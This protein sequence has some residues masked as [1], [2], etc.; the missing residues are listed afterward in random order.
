MIRY[1]LKNKAFTLIDLILSLLIISI[2]I[3]IAVERVRPDHIY[4]LKLTASSIAQD[5]YLARQL[6]V[7]RSKKYKVL[8]VRYDN[9]HPDSIYGENNANN[10]YYIYGSSEIFTTN[11]GEKFIRNLNRKNR[12]EKARLWTQIITTEIEFNSLGYLV[13]G[14]SSEVY[15]TNGEDTVE[16]KVEDISGRVIVN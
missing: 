12:R 10:F 5:I 1:I 7:T 3:S 16:I 2:L 9:L 14:S 8:F 6:S 11:T 13:T 15:L 4:S